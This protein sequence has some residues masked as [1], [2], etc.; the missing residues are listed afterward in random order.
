MLKR[1]G[2]RFLG[3]DKWCIFWMIILANS[4]LEM[5]A[6]YYNPAG[7]ILRR[8]ST[9]DVGTH[10]NFVVEAEF[11]LVPRV[12]LVESKSETNFERRNNGSFF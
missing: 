7:M 4:F 10:A 12:T 9:L 3:W 5:K 11:E 6:P 8:L 1:G 2:I